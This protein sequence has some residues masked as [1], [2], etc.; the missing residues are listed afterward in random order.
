MPAAGN[1]LQTRSRHGF[2]FRLREQSTATGD[3]GVG[4]EDKGSRHAVR[5]RLCF[6]DRKAPREITR[7]FPIHG[8][9]VELGGD[10]SVR[11]DPDLAEEIEAPRRCRGENELIAHQAISEGWQLN[12]R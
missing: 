7:Q 11:D 1:P 3:N 6:G 4:T 10:N 8:D 2:A 9:F 12:L 5:N